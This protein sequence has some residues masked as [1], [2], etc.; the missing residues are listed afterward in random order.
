MRIEVG[1]KRLLWTCT[2][3]N[4]VHFS[5]KYANALIGRDTVTA[6]SLNTLN[7]LNTYLDH[8]VATPTLERNLLEAIQLLGEL[9]T[10]GINRSRLMQLPR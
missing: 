5:L 4:D 2:G 1:A 3:I 10:L 9:K 7:T 6:M 8:G